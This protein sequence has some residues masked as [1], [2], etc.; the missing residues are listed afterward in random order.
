MGETATIT[1]TEFKATC[2]GLLD[3]LAA[4]EITRLEVTKR[5]KVV[6][7]LTPPEPAKNPVDELFGAMRGCVIAPPDFDFTAPV[8]D[9]VMHAAEGKVLS[10]DEPNPI[11]GDE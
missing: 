7:V 11:V 2:L 8:F 3:K 4:R 1:A 9:G 6:A 5:G 10:D